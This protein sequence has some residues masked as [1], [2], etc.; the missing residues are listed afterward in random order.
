M[1]SLP[2]AGGDNYRRTLQAESNT[3]DDGQSLS[4]MAGSERQERE[5]NTSA[6]SA[7]GRVDY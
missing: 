4:C 2:P 6:G 7:K 1:I 3:S 5:R